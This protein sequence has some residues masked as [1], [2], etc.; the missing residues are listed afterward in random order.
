MAAEVAAVDDKISERDR[1]TRFERWEKLGLDQVLH[2]LR[3]GGHRVVGGPP[4]VRQLA[5]EWARM[6]EQERQA[7]TVGSGPA[8]K[9]I[10]QADLIMLKPEIWGISVDLKETWRRIKAW[11]S[12]RRSGGS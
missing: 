7:V 3:N 6:K 1:R 9:T 8:P 12:M 4:Q 2:D 10:P 11:W 5:W